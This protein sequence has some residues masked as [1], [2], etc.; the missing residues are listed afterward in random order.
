MDKKHII[1]CLDQEIRFDGR[2]NQEYRNVSVEYDISKSAEGSARVKIGDTE[3]LAGVKVEVG[4][5]YPD[6]PDEGTIIVG[7]ELYPLSSPDFESGPPDIK[8]IELARVVDRGIRE[9][10]VIDFKDLCITP[11][12]KVWLL[13]IDI[14]TIND[15]GNLFDACS[16]AAL[17]AIKNM[18]FPELVDD[19]IDYKKKTDK[20]IELKEEPIEV[21][22]YKIGEHHIIDPTNEEEP[23]INGRLTVAST[24]EGKVCALQKGGEELFTI[25]EID[26]MVGIAIEKAGELRK[27]L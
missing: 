22:V 17:A 26:D 2:K 21:T 4:T 23:F 27:H 8:S 18:K 7:T 9:S 15:A 14:C 13:I 19:K 1:K 24:S 3:V 6:K 12:E 16:L 20:G 11:G 5:P 10:H 25:E